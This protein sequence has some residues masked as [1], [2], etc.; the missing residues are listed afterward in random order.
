MK[1][2]TYNFG[3]VKKTDEELRDTLRQLAEGGVQRLNLNNALL[4]H[5]IVTPDAVP[6]YEK[7]MKGYGLSFMD[8]HAPWGTWK[9]PGVPVE[10]EHAQIVMRQ[11][12]ALRL[13]NRF[14][15]T[16]IAYHTAN[17]F[18]S[19][20]GAD[21]TLND[22]YRMLLRTMEELLP[23][24]Q[25]LGVVMALENQWTPLNQSAC[26]LNAVRHFDTKWLGICYDSG[27]GNLTEHGQEFPGKT[28]VPTIW[29]DIQL[30]VVWE[31]QF[32]EKVRPYLINCHLHDNDGISDQHNLPGL[33]I[34]DWKRIMDNLANA[35][36]LQCIQCEVNMAKEGAPTIEKLVSTF[37]SL[38]D[39]SFF[40]SKP[41]CARAARRTPRKSN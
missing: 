41:N 9:D 1:P 21:L 30:P 18:N 14:G 22:Y 3:L 24:A 2:V 29:N 16:S 6:K 35:P 37:N 17:T 7:A 12:M 40:K 8:A 38:T 36:R 26:L 20:Y 34:V 10:S 5:F 11:K 25:K 23:D 32:I 15:V 19:I 39:G 4:E 31:E 13:C 27:H 28:V 33:G